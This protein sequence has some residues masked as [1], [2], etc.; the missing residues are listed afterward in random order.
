MRRHLTL[1]SACAV[2]SLLSACSAPSPR[3]EAKPTVEQL[4][5]ARRIEAVIYDF[6][7]GSQRTALISDSTVLASV[8]GWIRSHAWP[9][10]D[11]NTTG[12]VMP[13]GYFNVFDRPSDTSPAFQIYVFAA[14]SRSEPQVIHVSSGDWQTLLSMI[15]SK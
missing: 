6:D 11:L 8:R 3:S 13:R 10:I 2:A 5:S 7:T 12:N 1:L 14:T 9:P 4:E 15:P